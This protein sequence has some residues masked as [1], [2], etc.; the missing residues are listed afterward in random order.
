MVVGL[1]A[2][3]KA[4]GAYV[5]L[6]PA[7]PE[8]RLQFMVED[9]QP[10]A[11]LVHG[12]TRERFAALAGQVP[13]VDL[14]EDAAVW[15]QHSTSN[16]DPAALGLRPVHLAYVIYTSGST[17][18]P[19]GVMVEH[20]GVSAHCLN[21]SELEGLTPKDSVLLMAEIAFDPSVEQLFSSLLAGARVILTKFDLE[22]G[23]FSSHLTDHGVTLLNIPCLYWK[24]LVQAWLADPEL[25][26]GSPLRILI[27]GGDVMPAEVLSAWWQLPLSKS[28]RLYN[29]YG[30]T[31]T[32]VSAT[33]FAMG[34][35]SLRST[36]PIGRPLANRCTYVLDGDGQT[37]LIG[38]SGE[39]SVGGIGAAR[40][41]LN[42][43]EL[44]AER[45][46]PDP[47][48]TVPDARM[49]R[50]GDLA[51]W[52]PDG[53]L[54]YIGRVDFQIKIRGF[55]IELEEIEAALRDCEGIREAAVL[56]REDAPGEKRLVAYVTLAEGEAIADGMFLADGAAVADIH[57]DAVA[58]LPASLKAQLQ[59]RLPDTCCRPRLSSSKASLSRPTASLIARPCPL[60]RRRPTPAAPTPH[61][62]GRWRQPW[63]RSG[64]SCLGLSG[65]GVTIIS[66]PLAAIRFWRCAW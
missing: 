59:C 32:T 31:E 15:S 38:V 6:D 48:A 24:T 17:G 37:L 1:L 57:T 65:W 29:F 13:L 14:E 16:P 4:G 21:G 54:E 49:Y 58:R 36:I 28:T 43:T 30:P 12:A 64:A 51:R 7:Y 53:N 23:H 63:R 50:T 34:T 44:T 62:R 26:L 40:G 45:F 41:Y 9:S 27:V 56:A 10:V 46:L 8:E 42:R 22:P 52:L 3:L 60:Q 18:V 25:T 2:I 39:L 61:P 19:K 33:T 5:P 66:S 55:C 11:M 35:G 20:R 47:F